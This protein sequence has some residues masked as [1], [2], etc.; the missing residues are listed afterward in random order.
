MALCAI[1]V[2][3]VWPP[4]AM[5]VAIGM[6]PTFFAAIVDRTA[7][8]LAA[9]CVGLLNACGVL[10]F[11]LQLWSNGHTVTAAELLLT[12]VFD[13]SAMFA[14]AAVGWLLFLAIPPV[15][16]AV[17]RVQA[18]HRAAALRARQRELVEEWGEGVANSGHVR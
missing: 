2:I 7:G 14:A 13:L 8:K 10:P 11:V 15:V 4:T 12:N 6:L 17:L 5:V 1:A 3:A 9:R 18:E 16:S